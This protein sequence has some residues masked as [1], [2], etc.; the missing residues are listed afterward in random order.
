MDGDGGT[1]IE[2]W[3]GADDPKVTG[4]TSTNTWFNAVSRWDGTTKTIYVNNISRGTNNPGGTL[5]AV[6]GNGFII[7]NISGGPRQFNGK[8]AVIQIWNV[9]LTTA[10]LR[11]NYNTY[12]GRYGLT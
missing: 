3:W 12:K 4:I 2:Q 5:N 11:S 7:G 8:M 1:L 10:Q 9:A 6:I